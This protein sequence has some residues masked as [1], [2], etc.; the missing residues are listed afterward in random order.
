MPFILFTVEGTGNDLP[1]AWWQNRSTSFDEDKGEKAYQV[2]NCFGNSEWGLFACSQ[3]GID[4]NFVRFIS[5]YP[6][7]KLP[8]SKQPVLKDSIAS[9]RIYRI[10][11]PG[12]YSLFPS[13]TENNGTAVLICPGGGCERLAYNIS[14]TQLA[15]WFNSI[16]IS[17]FVL[18]YRF[19]NSSDLV[20][21]ANGPLQDVGRALK[22]IR[23][24][25]EHKYL[26]QRLL[27]PLFML[28]MISR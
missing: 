24:N 10:R 14:G 1:L 12:M 4:E 9:E 20:R 27:R 21:R 5:L 15:K 26:L 2:H 11:I 28:L 25:A 3:P 23:K 13:A 8:N 16:A 18:K 22:L 7:I 17:A 6:I 19:P